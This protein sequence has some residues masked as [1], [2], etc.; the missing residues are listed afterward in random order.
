MRRVVNL[1]RL[2]AATAAIGFASAGASEPAVQAPA[3]EAL[4][5]STDACTGKV[6][7]DKKMRE[8]WTAQGWEFRTRVEE[9]GIVLSAYRRGDIHLHYATA[10]IMKTCS[11]WASIPADYDVEPLVKAMTVK[12]NKVPKID[13]PGARY[14]FQNYRGLKILNLLVKEDQRGRYVELSVVH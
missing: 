7:S 13:A 6:S 10:S 14:Y 12:L 3:V 1:V 4:V 9:G 11:V 5:A 2:A 8:M